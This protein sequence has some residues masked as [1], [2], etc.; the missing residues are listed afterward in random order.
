MKRW[1]TEFTNEARDDHKSLDS[2]LRIQVDKAILKVAQNPLPKSEGGYGNPLGH[3][4]GMN[5]TGLFKITLK[6]TGIRVVYSI[7][8]TKHE[9]T[10]TVIAARADDEVYRIAAERRAINTQ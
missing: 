7:E 1:H 4:R 8:R 9:M 5:L 10:V 2:S 6:R 3:K